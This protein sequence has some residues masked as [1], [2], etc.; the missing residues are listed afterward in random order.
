MVRSKNFLKIKKHQKKTA[1][2]C[3][4]VIIWPA[5]E[6]PS[7]RIR[8]FLICKF[9]F[10]DTASI[11]TYSVNPAYESATFWIFS[12]EQKFLIRYESGIV[13]TLN[14]VFFFILWRNKIEPYSSL[15]L[16]LYSR[17]QPRSQVLS[18]TR[19]Y[20]A[21]PRPVANIPI[22]IFP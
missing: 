22:E 13:W 8:I 18:L 19:L 2:L 12:P 11:Y 1:A 5:T 16:I 4:K 17:W 10:P 15:P 9:F 7:T 6:G 14:P 21:C 3:W 20:D